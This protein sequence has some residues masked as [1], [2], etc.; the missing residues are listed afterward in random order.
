[1]QT[2]I[3]RKAYRYTIIN[4]TDDPMDFYSWSDLK[5]EVLTWT[6]VESTLRAW[7]FEIYDGPSYGF[8]E[9]YDFMIFVDERLESVMEQL[10]YGSVNKE[11]LQ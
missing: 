9:E 1:M 2:Q 4:S 5:R 7:F 11:Q 10:G 3:A 6:G 8:R